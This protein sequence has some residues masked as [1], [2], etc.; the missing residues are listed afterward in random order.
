MSGTNLIDQVAVKDTELLDW[1]E[2]EVIAITAHPEGWEILW[3]GEDNEPATKDPVLFKTESMRE[4]LAM[5]KERQEAE[6][7]QA[8][9]ESW[10]AEEELQSNYPDIPESSMRFVTAGRVED[11]VED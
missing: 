2:K 4:A 8:F 9:E 6:I 10:S 5:A 11:L 3:A 1:Q 7:V